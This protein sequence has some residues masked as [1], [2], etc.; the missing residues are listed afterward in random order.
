[1]GPAVALALWSAG[2]ER[3]RLKRLVV[4]AAG[5]AVM[6]AIVVVPYTIAGGLSNLL[7]VIEP[8]AASRHGVGE[9]V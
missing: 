5:G 1:M 3:R 4:G 9:R 8:R 2:P 7:F 6:I